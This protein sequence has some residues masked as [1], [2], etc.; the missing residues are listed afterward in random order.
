MSC[1]FQSHAAVVVVV[2]LVLVLVL[3]P[4]SILGSVFFHALRHFHVEPWGHWNYAWVWD[5]CQV[6]AKSSNFS[7]EIY[8][9]HL[10]HIIME[11][12]GYLGCQ[13]VMTLATQPL[14]TK[15][16]DSGSSLVKSGT[17]NKWH[18]A[19]LFEW[20]F[21]PFHAEAL[22]AVTIPWSVCCASLWRSGS[23][24]GGLV[25]GTRRWIGVA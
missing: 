14:S 21:F 22:A 4:A 23:R 7:L 6:W 13:T 15:A 25:L 8:F 12:S 20:F 2:V 18:E 10:G 24:S 3:V 19:D 16:I 11:N 1:C 9:H 5:I 17:A